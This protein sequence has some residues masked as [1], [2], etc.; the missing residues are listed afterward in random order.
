MTYLSR[1]LVGG[2]I[3]SSLRHISLVPLDIE[4]SVEAD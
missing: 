3:H 1:G 4:F 2:G